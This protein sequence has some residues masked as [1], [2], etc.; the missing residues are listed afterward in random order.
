MAVWL[1]QEEKGLIVHRRRNELLH[2]VTCGNN[3]FRLERNANKTKWGDFSLQVL[4]LAL[5]PFGVHMVSPGEPDARDPWGF[6]VHSHGHW[7]AYRHIVDHDIWLNLNSCFPRP[8]LVDAAEVV[9]LK[10]GNS[11]TGGLVF[12]VVG[13][14]PPSLKKKGRWVVTMASHAD[15]QD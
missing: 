4:Q 6:L 9:A 8:R 15:V 1:D 14:V 11:I 5:A 13:L 12:F 10:A 2:F 7:A 3:G